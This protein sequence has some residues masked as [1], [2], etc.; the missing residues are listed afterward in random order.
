MNRVTII[1]EAGVNHNGDIDLAFELV[2]IAGKANADFVKF[3]SFNSELLV[4][5]DGA[6][7]DYQKTNTPVEESQLEMLKKYELTKDDHRRIIEK[8]EEVGVKFLSTPFDIPSAEFL[9]R[10]GMGL[11]K[12]PSGELTNRPLIEFI[13]TK[14]KPVILSTG[15]ANIDEIKETLNVF[16]EFGLDSDMITLLHCTTEY[17]TPMED[18]NLLA[19]KTMRDTFKCKVGYSD[20]TLGIEIPI[21]AVAMGAV[22]IEKHF[23]KDRLLKGPDHT[24]SLEPNELREMVKAIRNIERAFGKDEKVPSSSELKN[25]AITRKSIHLANDM[26][27]GD[28]LLKENLIMLR[29][30]DG[31]SPMQYP[32]I[33]GKKLVTN[34]SK[35][36]K[37]A[38]S[39]FE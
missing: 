24:S 8:C 2:E 28:I 18:V 10:T 17:P 31:I 16:Y 37:L 12:I 29:P 1:A 6:K 23:T 3:Q 39:D 26:N 19:M 34:K 21:A 36:E 32:E 13:A 11:F 27:A 7:A 30:G 4:T 22:L 25:I 5:P 9:D 20:H 14:K 38:Q 35:F 15:M 33:V